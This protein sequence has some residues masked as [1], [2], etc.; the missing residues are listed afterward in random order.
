MDDKKNFSLTFPFQKQRKGRSCNVFNK[1][2]LNFEYDNEV[3]LDRVS[4]R[5]LEVLEM[6]I[7]V[8]EKSHQDEKNQ[9]LEK[10]GE[11]IKLLEDENDS[12]KIKTQDQADK[13]KQLDN[14]NTK[15]D[16]EIQ[17][18]RNR[19]DELSEKIS[20]LE[21]QIQQTKETT[22]E[23]KS[24]IERLKSELFKVENEL[25]QLRIKK[26]SD[27]K[28]VQ[29][30]IQ[31]LETKLEKRDAEMQS[32]IEKR[33]AEMQSKNE[34]RD[35]EMQSK[36]ESVVEKQLKALIDQMKTGSGNNDKTTINNTGNIQINQTN[37]NG[38]QHTH[39]QM[40]PMKKVT[41]VFEDGRSHE[42]SSRLRRERGHGPCG[43]QKT[44]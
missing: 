8:D 6:K 11:K 14:A 40:Y 27:E 7:N 16:R 33:D 18:L 43:R 25:Q 21:T 5:Q 17:K 41:P 2:Q 32:K 12:L 39:R 15:K 1:N 29:E 35:A 19:E 23:Q 42:N 26:E 24:E 22:I 36:F 4:M 44:E 37:S 10:S 13:I 28:S 9:I 30:Q 38:A 3:D 31:N 20:E 34:K